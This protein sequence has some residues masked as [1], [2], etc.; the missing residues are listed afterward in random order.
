[1]KKVVCYGEVLWDMLPEGK[2]PGGAPMNVAYHLNR[3][4]LE[5]YVVSRV[6]ADPL[7]EE[8][9]MFLKKMGLTTD[10][11]QVDADHKTSEV[12]ATEGANHEMS[13]DIVQPVAW[14]FIVSD[15]ETSTLIE[16]ADLMVFGTLAARNEVS[17]TTLYEL[18]EHAKLKLFDV[19]FRAPHYEQSIVDYLLR[20]ADI[21]KLNNHELR[22]IA[23]WLGG[24]GDNEQ[25]SINRLQDVYG[26]GELIVT[27][28]GDGASYYTL[29][30]RY[31]YKAYSVIVKDTVGSGDSF[32]AAFVAQKLLG[33]SIED[34]LDYAAAL[35]AYVTAQAGANPDYKTTDLAHFMW[36][37]QL[38]Q[39][40]WQ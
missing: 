29:T 21:V 27:K 26:I 39:L 7:G 40:K 35:G 19:N 16:S 37:K 25:E 28:G 17:R 34:M 36:R 10:Y 38:E 23:S 13:Y 20:K 1:M 11:I 12:I 9:T 15:T 14:D 5:S 3:L 18:I 32:L 31:D 6:G 4:G 30:E 2:K 22:I 24:D 8:L 33:K